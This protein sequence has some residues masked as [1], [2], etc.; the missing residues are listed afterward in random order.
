MLNSLQIFWFQ[1][2]YFRVLIKE[3]WNSILKERREFCQLFHQQLRRSY[4]SGEINIIQ[5]WKSGIPFSTKTEII[6]IVKNLEYLSFPPSTFW[7]TEKNIWIKKINKRQEKFSIK[8]N[9]I[10]FTQKVG[11]ISIFNL[12][13]FS[14][15]EILTSSACCSS[16][17]FHSEMVSLP[18]MLE[19][20]SGYHFQGHGFVNSVPLQ[21][22]FTAFPSEQGCPQGEGIIQC[23][24]SH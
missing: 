18:E 17:Q 21:H 16:S 14:Y 13:L 12:P 8:N 19:S 7:E 1:S 2:E 5:Y 9:K 10:T 24:S 22:T 20:L 6:A 23:D 15:L 4:I 11:K 3:N